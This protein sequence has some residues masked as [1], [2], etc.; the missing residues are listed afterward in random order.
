MYP[1][2]RKGELFLDIKNE[3]E[4]LG[5]RP[6][7]DDREFLDQYLN[8]AYEHVLNTITN[9]KII[10]KEHKGVEETALNDFYK[11]ILSTKN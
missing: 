6:T 7:R 5:I 10:A 9:Q 2:F 3:L 11:T 1:D 4:A 8:E